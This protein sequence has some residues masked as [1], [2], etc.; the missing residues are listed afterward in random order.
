MT[1]LANNFVENIAYLAA[2]VVIATLMWWCWY[3]F[4]KK[5]RFSRSEN[6]VKEAKRVAETILREAKVS[7]SEQAIKYRKEVE[8]SFAH[9]RKELEQLES[10]LNE[11]DI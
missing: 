6:V 2:G 5:S 1:L 7:A 3:R 10:R 8:E 4:L 11:R 9:E